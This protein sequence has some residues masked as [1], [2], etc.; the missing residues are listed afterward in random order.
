MSGRS[1]CAVVASS[2]FGMVAML[3]GMTTHAAALTAASFIICGCA[4]NRETRG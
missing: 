2:F 1:F 3:S 4:P